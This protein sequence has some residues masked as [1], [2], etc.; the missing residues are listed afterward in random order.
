[1]TAN[2]GQNDWPKF[3]LAAGLLCTWAMAWASI[4]AI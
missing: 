2:S 4:H 3:T 1:M